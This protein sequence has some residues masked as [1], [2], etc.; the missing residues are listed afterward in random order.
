MNSPGDRAFIL[1]RLDEEHAELAELITCIGALCDR[2][3]QERHCTGCNADH[4]S[5][6]NDRLGMMLRTLADTTLRHCLVESAYMRH[7]APPE[8]RAAHQRA[9]VEIAG[10][11]EAIRQ[12]F[13]GDHDAGHAMQAVLEILDTIRQHNLEFDAA[14]VGYLQAPAPH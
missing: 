1:Q 6:C 8:H 4:R 5:V 11:L 9:H 7:V 13:S 14:L 10:R 12:A 3:A 2:P